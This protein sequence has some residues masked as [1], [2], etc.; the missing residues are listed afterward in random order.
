MRL[1]G[2]IS[3]SLYLWH[4]PILIFGLRWAGV[5][6]PV[7]A[8]DAIVIAVALAACVVVATLSY[9]FVERPFLDRRRTARDA[10]PRGAPDRP[11]AEGTAAPAVPSLAS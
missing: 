10:A 6:A 3:Y 1:A 5:S 7:G 9:T 2:L 4:V 11:T 8:R